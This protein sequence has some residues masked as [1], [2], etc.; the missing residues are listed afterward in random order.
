M[1]E[2]Q[3]DR[4]DFSQWVVDRVYEIQD[5]ACT[6]CG[7]GLE[8][9]SFHR[10]HR[11]GDHSN[12]S[13]DNLELLCPQCHHSTLGGE[14][15]AYTEHKKQEHIVLEKINAVLDQILNPSEQS[16]GKIKPLSGTV[17]EQIV[18]AIGLSLKVSRNVT[19]IDYGREWM[20][21]SI[22]AKR[23][24]VDAMLKVESYTEGYMDAV[25]QL[26]SRIATSQMEEQAQ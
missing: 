17:V 21:A 19:D 2:G 12:T 14:F 22:K 20:P 25:K 10:H 11:D 26:M 18:D 3:D 5:G 8:Q 6:R 23:K 1:S 7:A 4:R 13:P 15:N 24:T 16:D 9:T